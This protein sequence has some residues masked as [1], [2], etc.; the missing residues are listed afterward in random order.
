MDW[1]SRTPFQWDWE[2]LTLFNA[3][4]TEISNPPEEPKSISE[5]RINMVTGSVYSRGVVKCSS[6]EAG[7]CPFQSSSP[8]SV[9]SSS[10]STMTASDIFFKFEEFLNNQN[11]KRGLALVDNSE[12]SEELLS[13]EDV[14]EP[15]IGLK[16]GRRM[17]FEDPCVGNNTKD[18]SSSASITSSTTSLKKSRVC[19]Q[20]MLSTYCQVEGC[21]VDLTTAKDYH[22]KHRVCERHS[23]FP[24][25]V[26]AGQ[27]RRFCQQCS[28]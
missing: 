26:V 12:T 18:S 17:Y 5:S 22:R 8:A 16:L 23:K 15:V 28:R 9:A 10:K 11:R 27:E 20:N 24:K 6:S 1:T 3:E 13:A 4:G 25:V 2:T 14:K 19:Q 21:K 7:D